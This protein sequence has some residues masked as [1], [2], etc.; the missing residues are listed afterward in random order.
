MLNFVGLRIL[1]FFFLAQALAESHSSHK[2]VATDGENW[3]EHL[4]TE[5]ASKEAHLTRIIEEL[6][7]DARHI[8]SQFD[9]TVLE[10]E[11]LGSALQDKKKVS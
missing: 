9:N 8:K 10:N 6:Q 11:C 2:R 5:A 4:L 1:A 3:E 7:N